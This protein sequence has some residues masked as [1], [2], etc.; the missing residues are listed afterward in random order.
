MPRNSQSPLRD[1][2]W[3]NTTV[4]TGGPIAEIGRLKDQPDDV[5]ALSR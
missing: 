3:N 5:S 4:L 2:E 1:P